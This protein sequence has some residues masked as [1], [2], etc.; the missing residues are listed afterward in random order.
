MLVQNVWNA[1]IFLGLPS[2]RVV[3]YAISTNLLIPKIPKNIKW[4]LQLLT[5]YSNLILILNWHITL[6]SNWIN[7]L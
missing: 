1:N 7:Q 6:V 3:L 4:I 2:S 5:N